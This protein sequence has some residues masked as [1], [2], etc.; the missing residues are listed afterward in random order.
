VKILQEFIKPEFY[1]VGG[2][3]VQEVLRS[4]HKRFQGLPFLYLVT[5]L[6]G[7]VVYVGQT[8]KT[9]RSRLRQHLGRWCF[10][11]RLQSMV[12]LYQAASPIYQSDLDRT[13]VALIQAFGPEWNNKDRPRAGMKCRGRHLPAKNILFDENLAFSSIRG[14]APR[15]LEA[16]YKSPDHSYLILRFNPE[17]GR[18]EPCP[19]CDQRHIHG[20]GS[21]GH[22]SPHCYKVIREG[23][24]IQGVTV[25]QESGYILHPLGATL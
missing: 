12:H 18:T 2:F 3:A 25:K 10:Q 13:E 11:I 22:K 9:P 16:E 21:G 17:T 20:I 8:S 15:I 1:Y 4:P 23:L 7:V 5:D 14:V 19:F 24:I 6:A